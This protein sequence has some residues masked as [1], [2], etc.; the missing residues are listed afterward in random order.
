MSIKQEAHAIV[1]GLADDAQWNDLVKA[2]YREKKITLGMTDLEVVQPELSES[3]ISSIISRMQ[4]AS[5][6]PDDMRNTKTYQPGNSA[7]LGM[8]AGLVAVLFSFVFPP[9]A[10]VAAPIAVVAGL[11]GIKNKEEKAWIPI[12]LAIVSAAPMIMVLS[13][14]FKFAS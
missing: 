3:Q 10:W 9:I 13:N 11:V 1:D 12:L 14:H 8:V 7:T 6:T 5:S 2:L 4:S